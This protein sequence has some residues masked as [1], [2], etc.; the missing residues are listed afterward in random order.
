MAR[1]GA[2]GGSSAARRSGRSGR[3]RP[4]ASS[5]T[6][7]TVFSLVVT[8][9]IMMNVVHLNPFPGKDLVFD[10]TTPTGGDFGAH[11][12]GPAYLR[13]H[14]LPSF[15]LNGWT[16]DWYAGM[17]AYR[18][19]MVLPALAIVPVNIDPA[20]RRGDEAGQRP[21]PDHAAGVLL[22]VR[23]AR[24]LPLA[25]ARAVR[26]RRVWR[27]R[28]TRASASTAATSS[29][30]WR[31]SSRSRSRSR[32][33]CSGSGCSPPGCAPGKY[34]VWASVLIAA[35]CVSHGIV[36]IFVVG[37][38][39]DVLASCGSTAPGSMYAATVGITALLLI[40]VVDR[41]VPAQPRVHDRH[42]VRERAARRQ[43]R[44]V[45]GHVLPAHGAA[46]HPDH[47]ARHHRLHRVHRAPPPER[48]GAR[49]HRHRCWSR[50]C[51]SPRTAC[52]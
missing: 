8:T 9:V 16:M 36:L 50:R 40:A 22:G 33:R 7:V 37:A 51:T 30:R 28:S 21:R 32:W 1:A 18:F 15:R 4:T 45:V 17:P 43:L 10:D 42:E 25:D 27:S 31:A 38:A 35:A 24:Q 26:V 11:V 6:S 41:A 48:R 23:P 52:P 5:A 14:L 3:G 46:R 39:V 29:R 12:W 34:R 19:Y 2:D 49:H 13:D 44:L 47:D 20:V